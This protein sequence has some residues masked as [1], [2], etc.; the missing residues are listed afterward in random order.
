MDNLNSYGMTPT[1]K[2]I[3]KT[4]QTKL[5]TKNL[6][7]FSKKV[8]E[9]TE[10]EQGQYKPEDVDKVIFSVVNEVYRARSLHPKFAS[11][12]EAYAV[13][14][15]ELEETW[16]EIKAN[17]TQRARKEMVQVAAMAIRFLLDVSE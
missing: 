17:N 7:Q 9:L 12:H 13:L 8:L 3:L 16:D 15:E 5:G 2:K 6:H 14:K 11:P 1:E 4:L 10:R